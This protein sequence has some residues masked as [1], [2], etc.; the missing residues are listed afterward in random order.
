M[1]LEPP[2]EFNHI[3]AGQIIEQRLSWNE[4]EA[5]C[6][7]GNLACMKNTFLKQN[8][9]IITLPKI[10]IG[11]VSEKTFNLLK[12]HEIGHCNGWRH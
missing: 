7:K 5:Y 8:I 1:I 3:Y 11:G 2:Q 9:C 10:G 4:L 12:R 6:G